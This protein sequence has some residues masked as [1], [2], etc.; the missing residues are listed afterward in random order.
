MD[1]ADSSGGACKSEFL[2]FS[3]IIFLAKRS[4]KRGLEIPRILGTIMDDATWYFLVI[5]TSHFVLI[6]TLLF[7]RVSVA[8][9]F[10]GLRLMNPNKIRLQEAIQLL[11]AS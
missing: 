3:L 2:T 11:P 4:Q 10:H 8:V 5:F 9:I 7:G 6:I 1:R